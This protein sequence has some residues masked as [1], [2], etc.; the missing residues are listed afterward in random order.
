MKFVGDT[1][2][3]ICSPSM[4]I[5]PPDTYTR[6]AGMPIG[7]SESRSVRAKVFMMCCVSASDS[8]GLTWL[9]ESVGDEGAEIISIGVMT[10]SRL[11]MRNFAVT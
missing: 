1:V 9:L 5:E 6:V 2:H 11:T 4:V 3:R 7:I 8:S 10:T